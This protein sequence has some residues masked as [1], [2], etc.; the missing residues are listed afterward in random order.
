MSASQDIPKLLGQWLEYTDAETAAIQASAWTSLLEIQKAKSGL[1]KSITAAM[2]GQRDAVPARAN[3]PFR[4][5]VNRLISLETRNSQL[6]S[7]KY[8]E[9]L[10]RKK[11][12]ERTIS[13][14]RKIRRSYGRKNDA[15]WN[16]FS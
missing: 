2:E 6:L 13:N 11:T 8:T 3:H 7:A 4:A 12:S 5:E 1:Q 16:S 9:A 14:L 15:G 10:D